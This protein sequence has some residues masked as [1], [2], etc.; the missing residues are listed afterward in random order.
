M[1]KPGILVRSKRTLKSENVSQ[2]RGH[3]YFSAH[4]RWW[5]YQHINHTGKEISICYFWNN[6]NTMGTCLRIDRPAKFQVSSLS[7]FLLDF[8]LESPLHGGLTS[9]MKRG[10][11]QANQLIHSAENWAQFP[12]TAWILSRVH[13][14][15]C[16]TKIATKPRSFRSIRCVCVCVGRGEPPRRLCWCFAVS[17]ENG[18][19]R[20][21]HNWG[22][23]FLTPAPQVISYLLFVVPC[24]DQYHGAVV[25]T[26]FPPRVLP[27]I[28]PAHSTCQSV[29]HRLRRPFQTGGWRLTKL[30]PW[31]HWPSPLKEPP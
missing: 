22:I 8:L 18:K 26:G 20:V 11:N 6:I 2:E 10:N 4:K 23:W 13:T 28:S 17:H 15:I 1:W 14:G 9:A 19:P 27:L 31:N 29:K 25:I 16:E 7:E 24:G 12:R 5:V 3:C 21:S 30:P